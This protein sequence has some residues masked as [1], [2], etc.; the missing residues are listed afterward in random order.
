MRGGSGSKKSELGG[1]GKSDKETRGKVQ[2]NLSSRFFI[3]ETNEKINTY[4]MVLRSKEDFDSFDLIIAQYGDAGRKDGEMSSRLISVMCEG[5]NVAFTEVK[6][7]KGQ[8]TGYQIKSL[9]IDKDS[10]SIYDI[11][12]EEKSISALQ[13]INSK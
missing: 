13:I 6:N 12:L 5:K 4:K 11:M 9:F 7:Q 8:I 1:A 10:P 2:R 3:S